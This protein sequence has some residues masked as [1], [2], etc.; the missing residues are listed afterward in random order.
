MRYHQ[1]SVVNPR[2]CVVSFVVL[3]IKATLHVAQRDMLEV[4]ADIYLLRTT[5]IVGSLSQHLIRLVRQQ[6]VEQL[7][8][9][10]TS[11]LVVRAAHP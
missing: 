7:V 9:C 3:P 6:V 4:D 8:S 5:S 2:L 10:A 1:G 11:L